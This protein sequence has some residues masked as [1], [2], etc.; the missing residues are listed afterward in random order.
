MKIVTVEYRRLRTFGNYENE[1]VGVVAHVE[2]DETPEAALNAARA[3]VDATLCDAQER[4]GLSDRVS[5]LRLEA[6]NLERRLERANE[7]WTALMTFMR[8]RL[9][10]EHPND[11]PDTLEELPF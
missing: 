3:W 11:L 4:S 9:G 7:K 2:Q 8:D 6:A 5:Y 1:S 10:I